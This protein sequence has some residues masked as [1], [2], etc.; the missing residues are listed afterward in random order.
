MSV[1]TPYSPV[2]QIPMVH[3]VD[4]D[5]GVRKALVRLLTVSGYAV[6]DYS[7]ASSFLNE[8]D[9]GSPGCLLLDFR[10]P[11]LSGLDVFKALNTIAPALPVILIT[12]HGDIDLSVKIMRLGAV[13]FLTKPFEEERLL[14]SIRTAI[15]L[16]IARHRDH[17][18]RSRLQRRYDMLT[19][20]ERE[21]CGLV[22]MG[23]LNKQVAYRLGIAEKTIKIHRA[24]VMAKLD[25][26][27]VAELVR[28]VDR[29]HPAAPAR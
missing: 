5:E 24:R 7:N 18:E 8:L 27:S 26:K 20:R 11:D 19:K 1:M 23:L 4:D 29:L 3:V 10:M 21:V 17:Q 22:G 28:F 12:G 6:R 16:S 15:G 14:L 2:A 25:V 13:D 9:R